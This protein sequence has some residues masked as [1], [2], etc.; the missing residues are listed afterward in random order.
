M[1]LQAGIRARS[2]KPSN[3]ELGCE[4]LLFAQHTLYSGQDWERGLTHPCLRPSSS[5]S[6]LKTRPSVTFEHIHTAH[7]CTGTY[8]HESDSARHHP[9]EHSPRGHTIRLIPDTPQAPPYPP[10]HPIKKPRT[11]S[12]LYI[13]E[14]PES[15]SARGC[16]M[17]QWLKGLATKPKELRLFPGTLLYPDA[18][19]PLAPGH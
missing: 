7:A 17:T 15:Q 18:D 2:S 5:S 10:L 13:D 12:D 16:E 6:A 3:A 1:H 4:G 9:P 19:P 11:P 14:G 8:I